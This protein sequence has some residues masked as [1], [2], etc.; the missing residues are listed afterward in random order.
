MCNRL[1]RHWQAFSR[2]SWRERWWLTQGFLVL[3]PTA[4]ALHCWGLRRLQRI[5]ARRAPPAK[6]RIEPADLDK[7]LS[8]ARMLGI[9]ARCGWYQATCL[10]RSLVLWWWLRRLGI[11]SDLRIGV[12]QES[13]SF[14]AHAW[15]ECQGLVLN[16]TTDVHQHFAAFDGDIFTA[17][18]TRSNCITTG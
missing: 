13:G 16:E 17:E 15:I 11:E 3:P 4:V 12:R 1:S 8:M 9:A 2:L 18:R 6:G 5:F 14:T 7:A 10:P